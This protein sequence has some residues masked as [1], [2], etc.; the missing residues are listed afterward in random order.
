[1][2][3]KAAIS[4]VFLAAIVAAAQTSGTRRYRRE[5]A[6]VIRISQAEMRVKEKFTR[7]P[8]Q[9][10]PFRSSESREQLPQKL[11]YVLTI[12]TRL[13]LLLPPYGLFSEIDVALA[14][15]FTAFYLAPPCLRRHLTR[16]S[17]HRH[18]A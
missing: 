1:M 5:T 3:G 14:R 17:P 9:G 6:R 4:L 18:G 2:A 16:C 11:K 10:Q 13:A 8:G 12:T 15:G 7:F